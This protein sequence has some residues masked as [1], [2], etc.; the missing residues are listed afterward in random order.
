M[1]AREI[2]TEYIGLKDYEEVVAIQEGHFNRLFEE[3]SK[4]GSS[5]SPMHLLLCQHSPVYTLGRNGDASNLLTTAANSD[6]VMVKC[7][8]GGDITYHGP[9]Q[10][11]GYPILDLERLGIGLA[12]YI[13]LLE[14]S[15]IQTISHFGLKGERLKG[16]AGVW[17]DCDIPAKTRKICAIGIRSSRW[18]TMP[19]S[20]V[21]RS[22]S[23]APTTT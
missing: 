17:L 11:I 2:R 20:S 10:L 22:P 16:A 21:T 3:K 4:S 23:T 15:V 9:G 12:A 1:K 13:N 19:D 8:R 6:A 14:E 7:S 18:L 5:S